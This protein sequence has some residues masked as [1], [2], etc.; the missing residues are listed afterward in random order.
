MR[1]L[2]DREVVARLEVLRR[3]NADN[4]MMLDAVDHVSRKFRATGYVS[5]DDA[6]SLGLDVRLWTRNGGREFSPMRGDTCYPVHFLSHTH[7]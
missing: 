7:N 3:E 1:P 2:N 6:R 5:A 4:P